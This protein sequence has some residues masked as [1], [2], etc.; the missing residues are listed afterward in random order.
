MRLARRFSSKIGADK[1]HRD[2][3]CEP[4]T[5]SLLMRCSNRWFDEFTAPY[6]RYF[7]GRRGEARAKPF[8]QLA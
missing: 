2:L 3:H 7:P 6:V 8:Q 4:E 5:Q 1:F